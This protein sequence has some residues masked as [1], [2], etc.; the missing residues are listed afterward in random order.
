MKN[1]K[2]LFLDLVNQIKIE[3]SH[4]EIQSMVYIVMEN[5]FSISRSD[6]LS[7]KEVSVEPAEQRGIERIIARINSQEPIQYI[8][9]GCEFY[10][11]NFNLNSS[12]LIP[13]PETEELVSVI[14]NHFNNATGDDRMRRL[15]DIGTGSGCIAI[16]LALEMARA[17]VIATDI[18]DRALALASNNALGLDANVQFLASDILKD[19]IPWEQLDLVVSNPPYITEQEKVNLGNNIIL[20]EPHIAL[21]VPDDDPLRFYRSI[22][23]KAARVLRPKGLLAVEINERFG[24]DVAGVFKGFGFSEIAVITDIFGKERIVKGILS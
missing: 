14:L 12:A 24:N 19:E 17:S 9:G 7:E 8:V 13:R 2:A 1:S 3:E 21:F 20:F 10:G 4:D 6:I 16:T 18:S 23:E 11:R 22:A 5:L 15:V